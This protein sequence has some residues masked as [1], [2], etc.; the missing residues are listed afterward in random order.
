V[1]PSTDLLAELS[2][3]L[4]SAGLVEMRMDMTA[5]ETSGLL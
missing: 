2:L 4:G 1:I 3:P 5:I